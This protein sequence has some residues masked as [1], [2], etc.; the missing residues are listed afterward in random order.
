[1]ARNPNVPSKHR[2]HG[3]WSAMIQRCCNPN[4]INYVDYGGRGITICKE[5]RRSYTVFFEWAITNGYA[6]GK[7]L[8]RIDNDFGYF[9]DNCRFVTPLI[10]LRNRRNVMQYELNGEKRTLNEW[11]AFY[12]IPNSVLY[13]RVKN[14]NIPLEFAINYKRRTKKDN[15]PSDAK[16]TGETIKK[17][18]KKN[19]RF[20][21]WIIHRLNDNGIE[22]NESTF[23]NKLSGERDGFLPDEIMAIY[24][25]FKKHNFI[26]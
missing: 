25:I 9:P 15:M 1:M 17:I 12:D 8:D 26:L 2:L 13:N 19:G 10:S 7:T 22:I 6:V 20:N 18:I 21:Y 14:K 24:G 23:S 5:W 4:C 11:A 16:R 3:V